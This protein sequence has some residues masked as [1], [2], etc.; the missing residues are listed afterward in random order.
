MSLALD[1]T[2][3][4]KSKKDKDDFELTLR[5]S[6]YTMGRLAELLEE[7]LRAMDKEETKL[8]DFESPGWA[9]KQAFRN[10]RRKALTEVLDLLDFTR[11]KQS[12]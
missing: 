10:G 1:W 9:Y 8:D 6:T 3:H 7:R 5:N 2:K 12:L 4:L 11:S